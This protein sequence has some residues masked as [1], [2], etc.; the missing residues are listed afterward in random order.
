MKPPSPVRW[1]GGG[2]RG[3]LNG[4]SSRSV[5]A[6][7]HIAFIPVCRGCTGQRPVNRPSSISSSGPRVPVLENP[8]PSH[9]VSA[10]HSI[11][12]LDA[13]TVISNLLPRDVSGQATPNPDAWQM[14]LIRKRPNH[15]SSAPSK[16]FSR[17]SSGMPQPS[18]L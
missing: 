9:D 13:G 6:G 7:S 15:P 11:V 1:S 10:D 12:Y 16:I 17:I 3:R 8:H 4:C 14:W 18:S 2:H 5:R